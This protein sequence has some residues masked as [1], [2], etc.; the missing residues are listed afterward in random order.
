M[1][2]TEKAMELERGLNMFSGTEH[3]YEHFMPGILFTDGI[4]YLAN[5]AKAYWLIDL[6]ASWQTDKKVAK[7]SFQVWIIRV[8]G[9]KAVVTCEDGNGNVVASQDIPYTDFPLKEY[10][11]YLED[12]GEHKVILLTGEH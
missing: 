11:V 7:E 3:W 6:I 5:E 10:R 4:K 8:D 2:T 9:T 1:E 12:D